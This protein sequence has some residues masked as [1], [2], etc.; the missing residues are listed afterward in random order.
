MKC[1]QYLRGLILSRDFSCDQKVFSKEDLSEQKTEVVLPVTRYHSQSDER[2]GLFF[3]L[4][5]CGNLLGIHLPGLADFPTRYGVTIGIGFTF[6]AMGMAAPNLSA[7]FAGMIAT[8][9]F[10][11]GLWLVL[12]GTNL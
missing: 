9:S 4:Q 12:S 6:I 10:G 8:A 11:Y 2:A 7:E 5:F 1:E 3:T